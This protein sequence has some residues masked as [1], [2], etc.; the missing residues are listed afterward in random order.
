M[1]NLD[2]KGITLIT[3]VITIIVLLI[4]SSVATYSGINVINSSKLTTF[5]TEMKLMQSEV[6]S[7]YNKAKNGEKVTVNGENYNGEEIFNLGKSISESPQLEQ[8][9]R[10]FTDNES[11]IT[12]KS[13]YKYFDQ[14]ILKGLNIEGINQEF[15]INIKLRSIVSYKGLQYNNEMYY[16]LEQLPDSVYNVNYNNTNTGKPGI[17]VNYEEIGNGKYRINVSVA[18]TGNIEKWDVKY[19][20]STDGENEW[21]TSYDISFIV[22]KTGKYIIKVEN[23]GIESEQ[24][25]LV[26]TSSKN[27]EYIDPDG[28][29]AIIPAGFYTSNISGEQT[30]DTGLVVIDSNDNEFVWIPCTEA[31]YTKARDSSW[32]SEGYSDKTWTDTQATTTGLESIKQNGGFYIARY[33]AGIPENATDIYVNTDGGTYTK[34]ERKNVT[35]YVP[36]SKKN[37]QAWNFI[38][39]IN[40]KIVAENMITN[41]TVKSYLVDSYAWNAVCRV[42]SKKETN[43]S[44][45]NSTNW[46]NYYDN[47]TTEYEKLNTLF[48]VHINNSVWTYA[49]TYKKGQVTGAPK[50]GIV[51][52][53]N[54]L[55]LATG[56]SDDF[57]AYNVYDMAG[58]MWEWTTETSILSNEYAILRGG[59]LLYNGS[60]HSAIFSDGVNVVGNFGVDIGFRVMLYL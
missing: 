17:S 31:E 34:N 51:S 26:V 5:T 30:I 49:K 7:L 54:R 10:V 28:K 46:G 11:G 55:E 50:D 32:A 24:D 2:N 41:S 42:I 15:F 13:D 27:I 12:D 36:V 19:K 47:I 14:S 9:N 40:S 60:D 48:A 56:A 18:Y 52:T 38:S 37:V 3:L 53:T 1:K 44:I 16:T 59:S 6:N 58:N 4:L 8:A 45:T 21:N 39:Q 29:V 25:E 57:K 43:K 33:E 22:N 35:T 20:L 23:N